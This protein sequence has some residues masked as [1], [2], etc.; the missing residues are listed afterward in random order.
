[1][2]IYLHNFPL[3]INGVEK[4]VM[5]R[6]HKVK[7]LKIMSM[8]VKKH[9]VEST[10]RLGNTNVNGNGFFNSSHNVLVAIYQTPNFHVP[11]SFLR[12]MWLIS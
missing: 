8:L 3:I 1:M 6:L 4:N 9:V 7:V 2:Q 12:S 11:M 10:R 5:T